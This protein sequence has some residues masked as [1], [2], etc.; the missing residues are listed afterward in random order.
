MGDPEG[1]GLEGKEGV[2]TE[3]ARVSYCPSRGFGVL[4]RRYAS[5]NLDKL[6]HGKLTVST[7]CV[8]IFEWVGVQQNPVR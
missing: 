6:L 3:I 5:S 4:E 7:G 8:K 2:M 1:R